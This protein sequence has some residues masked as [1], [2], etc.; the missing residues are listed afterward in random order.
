[1][2]GLDGI[3]DFVALRVRERP[4][5]QPHAAK[6]MTHN[7]KDL[8]KK[9]TDPFRAILGS[10]VEVIRRS[11]PRWRP[12]SLFRRVGRQKS[13]FV[14]TLESRTRRGKRC[15]L[16][17]NGRNQAV[18]WQSAWGTAFALVSVRGDIRTP[19]R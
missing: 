13:A 6:A 18:F 14:L 19:R 10:G 16:A 3:F 2:V 5:D 1:L 9:N 7:A 8:S 15:G 11:P 12:S 17:G 4:L